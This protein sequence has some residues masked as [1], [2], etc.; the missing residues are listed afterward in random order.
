MADGLLTVFQGPQAA[1]ALAAAGRARVVQRWSLDAMVEG[2]QRL[3][4]GI[5]Q[6]KAGGRRGE[7]AAA[8]ADELPTAPADAPPVATA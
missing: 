5:H 7:P 4:S 2:Y 6:Q 3:I 1:A 8:P